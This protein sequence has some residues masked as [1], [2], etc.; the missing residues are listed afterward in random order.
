MN[1]IL[2]KNLNPNARLKS[3][4]Y[5]NTPAGLQELGEMILENHYQPWFELMHKDLPKSFELFFFVMLQKQGII[6]LNNDADFFHFKLMIVD[7][8]G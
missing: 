5:P 3:R 4:L 1:S 7:S 8:E 2:Y 6:F